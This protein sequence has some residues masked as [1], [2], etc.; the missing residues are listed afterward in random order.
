MLDVYP[1]PF[2]TQQFSR[3]RGKC[4]NADLNSVPKKKPDCR[5]LYMCILSYYDCLNVTKN[6]LCASLK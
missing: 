6:F 3:K 4:T 5:N 2:F 1:I